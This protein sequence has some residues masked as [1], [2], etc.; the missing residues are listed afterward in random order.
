MNLKLFCLLAKQAGLVGLMVGMVLLT[1]CTEETPE[2]M[3][4]PDTDAAQGP[5]A[6]ATQT[7]E[8]TSLLGQP[9]YRQ[10]PSP[11][12]EANLAEAQANFDQDADDVENIIWLGRRL[13]YL[14]RYQDAIAVYTEGI[15]KYPD[16]PK[17]YRH[18]GHRYISIRAFDKA[19]ADLERAADLIEGTED[20]VEP[21]GQPNDAGI[22]TSTLHT[23]V[24]YHLGLA[25]YLQGHFD[26]ALDAYQKCLAA[27]G[28]NDMRVATLDWLYMTL[29]RL[30]RPDEADA[31]IASVHADMQLLENFAYH[32]RL[33][34]YKGEIPPDSLLRV[35]DADDAALTL[36][37]QGY[38]VGN[39]YLVS[40]ERERAME[41]FRQVVGGDYWPAFG[42][43]A[44]EADLNRA[45]THDGR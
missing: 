16:E 14:W 18:R 37:T 30:D 39:Y 28:N 10:A 34:M 40:G 17:L 9:L 5:E 35:D 29:R 26:K 41:I 6:E 36:A 43:L 21:D 44:A 33:L 27:A 15:R 38:G 7:P 32:R 8:A 22:P 11:D 19:V 45:A 25:Y 20:E 4:P 3:P 23:N 42:Y 1:G 2:A 31:A 12:A 24:F 13:A